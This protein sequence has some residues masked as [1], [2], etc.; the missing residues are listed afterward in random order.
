M[1]THRIYFCCKLYPTNHSI[2]LI[3]ATVVKKINRIV[4]ELLK[5]LHRH[6][7]WIFAVASSLENL[8]AWDECGD[9]FEDSV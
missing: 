5:A 3:I 7:L 9:E 6:F 8:F 2:F 1:G 4:S